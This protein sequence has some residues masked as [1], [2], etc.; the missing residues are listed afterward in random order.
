M[1]ITLY[2]TDSDPR[3]LDKQLSVIASDLTIKPLQTFSILTP[4]ITLN[5]AL[6]YLNANYAYISELDRYYFISSIDLELGKRITF[7]C[8]VDVLMSYKD[9]IKNCPATIVRSEAYPPGAVVDDKLPVDPNKKELKV[10][11]FTPES[12][13]PFYTSDPASTDTNYLLGV[14]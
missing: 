3:Q 9:S 1:T 2:T 14:M 6:A 4:V 7:S 11:E 12:D 10:I 8:T 5:Y 13:Y